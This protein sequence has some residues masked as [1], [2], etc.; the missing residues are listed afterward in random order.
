GHPR[1]RAALLRLRRRLGLGPAAAGPDGDHEAADDA[2]RR[3]AARSGRSALENP[4]IAYFGFDSGASSGKI[5]PARGLHEPVGVAA[6]GRR[7]LSSDPGSNIAGSG[8][9]RLDEH[10]RQQAGLFDALL[11]TTRDGYALVDGQGHILEANDEFAHMTGYGL[12]ELAGMSIVDLEA[13]EDP[14][15]VSEHI[16]R[17]RTHGSDR[18]ESRH[19]TRDGRIIDVEVSVTYWQELDRCL[20]FFRDI[21][22]RNEQT[23]RL[24]ESENRFR[25]LL[26]AVPVAILLLREGRYI[27]GNPES[28]RLLGYDDAE[29]IVGLEAEKTIAPEQLVDI[30]ERRSRAGSGIANDPMELCVVTPGGER[31]WS[32]SISIPIVMDGEPTILIAGQ[33]ITERKRSQEALA[34]TA[35]RLEAA[36]AAG[37]VGLWD[38]NLMTDRVWYS[39]EWKS[40]IG[41]AP[42][43]VGDTFSEWRDRVHPDDVSAAFGRIQEAMAAASDTFEVEF[44]FRHRSG[45]WLWILAHGTIHRDVTGQAVRILGSHIDITTQK[46]IETELRDSEREKSLLLNTTGE[47]FV[48]HDLDLRIQWANAAA[49]RS[50]GTTVPELIGRHCYEIW[51]DRDEPCDV[52]PVLEARST[53]QPREAEITDP[54]GR[55]WHLRGYPVTDTD[56]TLTA[57]IEFGQDITD[58]KQAEIQSGRQLR[59]MEQV[60]DAIVITDP[61]GTIEYVNPAFERMTG[62]SQAEV[63]GENPRILK[64][65]QHDRSFYVE[66]W[67]T[68]GAGRTWRGR[69]V[70][71]RHDGSLFTEECVISPVFDA[72]DAVVNF[73]AVKRDIT[74][75]LRLARETRELES[76]I[77]QTQ[78]LESIGRLA[79][80]VAHDLNNLLAPVIGYGEM[81]QGELAASDRRHDAATSIVQAGLRARDLVRQLLTFSRKQVLEFTAI[82]LNG[83]L[84]SFRKLLRR[85]IREDI[86]IELAL[87]P[88]LPIVRGDVGQLEQVVMNLAVNA[89]DAMPDGGTLTIE[90]SVVELDGTYVDAHRGTEPGHYVMMVISDTGSGM[91]EEV[92]ERIFEPFFTTKG[93]D[94]GTGLGLA[95]TYGIIKQH[96]GN[97]WVYSEPGQGSTFKV[98]LPV[99]DEGTLT[100]VPAA[101]VP[102]EQPALVGT[103]VVLV[104]E[105]NS[106]VR[107][108][109]RDILR[110]EGYQVIT[111]RDGYEALGLVR[112]QGVEPDIL[113][114]D[115][116]MPGLNGRELFERLQGDR[117]DLRVLYMSGYTDDVIV[118]R[119]VLDYETQ[120]I[121]KP[122]SRL[123]LLERVRAVLDH[124]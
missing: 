123:G 94:A 22:A 109:T 75:E 63:L 84:T 106:D 83:L 119:G 98:Y 27:Y 33:D 47:L 65:G 23:H 62:Y 32:M 40:Q 67:N 77:R 3:P 26:D 14:I 41:H 118:H 36:V 59:S 31:R 124:A 89:Q 73:V 12:D 64:S 56:G 25:T 24:R 16:D 122:F 87:S 100:P 76:Q 99:Q 103:E 71:R 48:Y 117:P 44:R 102:V 58:R 78:K 39:D 112:D 1:A 11:S 8:E 6:T 18:F 115:V 91:T 21:T 9:A 86:R 79:G 51:H 107:H 95:T 101:T 90:T 15:E 43:E 72:T 13:N 5:V 53:G 105:D 93:S 20:S 88:S 45:E 110:A 46:Q 7:P 116:V 81:L 80:G 19:R 42:D 17:V 10:T 70:N 108:L 57:L 60:S 52:C 55:H 120:F 114:T 2:R 113:L 66:M 28:A 54:K 30:R 97:I 121:Q 50:V 4:V 37:R 49:A 85:T 38:W 96:G 111:A 74:E 69:M 82:D 29:S 35:R 61:Q 68:L 34:E 104:A 92:S